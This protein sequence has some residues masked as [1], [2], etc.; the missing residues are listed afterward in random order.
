MTSIG[1]QVREELHRAA[2]R[3]MVPPLPLEDIVATGT[4]R[5]RI[6]LA[7]RVGATILVASAIAG[8]ALATVSGL[9]GA[10]RT[11]AGSSRSDP[12]AP[13]PTLGQTTGP[14]R[15]PPACRADDVRAMPGPSVSPATGEVAATYTIENV[16]T[17]PCTLFGIPKITLLAAD[18]TVLPLWY[19]HKPTQYVPAQRPKP[20][21]VSP[22]QTTASLLVA[23]YRC[24][25]GDLTRAA[26]IQIS[27]SGEPL[28]ARVGNPEIAY[29][30]GGPHDPG[31]VVAVS[32]F[33]PAQ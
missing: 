33:T 6:N 25:G 11:P 23:K 21:I 4:R 2:G 15:R 30:R 7:A 13:S 32:A 9:H 28:A 17:T 31:Q 20:V 27:I 5:R 26:T 10:A 18:G 14:G 3:P 22:G 1:D 8:I 16:S 19:T 24:D 29:C 12:L